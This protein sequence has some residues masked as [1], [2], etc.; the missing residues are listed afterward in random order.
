MVALRPQVESVVV[1]ELQIESVTALVLMSQVGS[2]IVAQ[3]VE[4]GWM[5]PAGVVVA[6][7]AVVEDDLRLTCG[8]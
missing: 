4:S 7:A 8:C 5:V 3:Q 2:E 1:V 6:V